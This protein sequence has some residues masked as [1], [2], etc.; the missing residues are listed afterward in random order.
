MR[1]P[2]ACAAMGR[3]GRAHVLAHYSRA[4][5]SAR[6]ARLIREITGGASRPVD[7]HG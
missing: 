6:Y 1:D 3:A 7:V 4:A 5:V 2:A